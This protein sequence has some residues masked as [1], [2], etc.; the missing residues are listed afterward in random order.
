MYYN[1][2]CRQLLGYTRGYMNNNIEKQLSIPPID[3]H[4]H[5]QEIEAGEPVDQ[6]SLENLLKNIEEEEKSL[7]SEQESFLTLGKASEF[8]ESE[9]DS[10]VTSGLLKKDAG[11]AE[12]DIAIALQTQ[13]QK[14]ASAKISMHNQSSR[15]KVPMRFSDESQANSETPSLVPMK[16][17][18]DPKKAQAFYDFDTGEAD[19]VKGS[20]LHKMLKKNK[21]LLPRFFNNNGCEFRVKKWG[22]GISS[23]HLNDLVRA[24][25]ANQAYLAEVARKEQE[26]AREAER[27][28]AEAIS[29]RYSSQNNFTSEWLEKTRAI[30]RLWNSVLLASIVTTIVKISAFLVEKWTEFMSAIKRRSNKEL[31]KKIE[32][33]KR[34]DIRDQRRT[35]ESADNLLSTIK[36]K[37]IDQEDLEQHDLKRNGTV[38]KVAKFVVSVTIVSTLNTTD[39]PVVLPNEGLELHNLFKARDLNQTNHEAQ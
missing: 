19:L 27:V 37:R 33:N 14:T 25:H 4:P 22:S 28:Q 12:T 31:E 26:K 21:G 39:H 13:N 32:T 8:K 3:F 16:P 9:A 30:T 1:N 5:A 24:Y 7:S 6:E 38:Q 36:A 17:G 23:S 35:E 11:F 29:R 15:P 34:I 18:E 20:L 10:K 2:I